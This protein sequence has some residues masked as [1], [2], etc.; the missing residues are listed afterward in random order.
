MAGSVSSSAAVAAPIV[1]ARVHVD[2][3]DWAAAV[4]AAA[5]LLVDAGAATTAYADRCVQIV[6]EQGPYIVIAPGIAL[7]H[8]R[9]ED[10]AHALALSAVTLSTPVRFGHATNDPVDLVLA[11]ASPDHNTHVGLLAALARR[12]GDDLPTQLRTAASADAAVALL[13]EV[14]DDVGLPIG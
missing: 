4:H 8:A 3:T 9:P 10:G 14:V 11:F 1:A 7:A 12:L 13:Q 2:A 6:R 5:Q